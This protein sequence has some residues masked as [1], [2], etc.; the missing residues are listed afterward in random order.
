MGP[1]EGERG[2][3]TLSIF[4]SPAVPVGDDALQWVPIRRRL[5]IGAFGVNAY[6]AAR[7]GEPVIEDHAE[8]PGQEELYIV[9]SGRARF[10]IGDETIDVAHGTCVLVADPDLRRGA[11]ALEDGT[12]VVA[13][14]G[15][16][17]RAYGSL[18]WEPI[19]LAQP[20][21]REGDWAGAAEVLELESGEHRDTAI[22]NYRLAYCHA[23]LGETARALEELR[24]AI[25]I[26][27]GLRE[28]AHAEAA[29]EALRDHE[30]W[31]R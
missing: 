25:E 29:F 11:V 18:P 22:V 26:N 16:R 4:D 28:R 7:H 21:M 30:A 1:M 17:G 10:T 3:R 8:S 12:A 13:V 27:P 2:Y 20:A 23:R 19:Y 5:D 15:W 24:R 6:R 14:G 9:L 31:P